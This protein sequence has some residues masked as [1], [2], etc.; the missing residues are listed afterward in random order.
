MQT[1]TRVHSYWKG[2]QGMTWNRLVSLVAQLKLCWPRPDLL[3]IHLGGGND[4]T[5]INMA[6]MLKC[7]RGSL[8]SIRTLFPQC[9]IGW[10]DIP[11]RLAWTY[12]EVNRRIRAIVTEL[13][14]RVI[15]HKNIGPELYGADMVL[16]DKGL[17]RFRLNIQEFVKRWERESDLIVDCISYPPMPYPGS[18]MLNLGCVQNKKL[19][20]HSLTSNLS[21]RRHQGTG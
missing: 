10:S 11:P 17:Q 15:I 3:I 8:A 12:F 18:Q 5:K 1:G 20:P 14:G 19:D 4:Y 21:S 2:V 16:S 9:L 6:Q 7:I 13:R